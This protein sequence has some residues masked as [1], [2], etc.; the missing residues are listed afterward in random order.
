MSFPELAAIVT[1]KVNG[2]YGDH[3]AAP[4]GPGVRADAGDPMNACVFVR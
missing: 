1:H 3:A 4:A 2:G